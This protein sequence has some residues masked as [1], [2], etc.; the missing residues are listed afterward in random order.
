MNTVDSME[1]FLADITQ[2]TSHPPTHPPSPQSNHLLLL[3]PTH[4]LAHPPTHPPT[5]KGR[6][7]TVLP[8]VAGLQLPQEKLLA[9]YEQV[10]LEL[11]EMRET[12]LA[13]EMLRTTEPL[14]ALKMQEPERYFRLETFLNRQIHDAHELYAYGLNKDRRRQELADMLA[15]EVSVVPPSRLL[16]L[17]QQALKYQQLQ[18]LLPKDKRYDLFRGGA[19]VK[20]KDEAERPPK[21]LAGQVKFGSKT[22]PECARFSPDGQHLVTGSL[23]GFVEVWDTDSCRLRKELPYQAKE[24]FMMHDI[25]VLCLTFSRDGEMLVSG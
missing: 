25:A 3:Y 7:D 6:W 4:P 14:A 13:R 23:D 5:K 24:E 21:K 16:A 9:V 15:Q 22:H 18:G 1:N 2:G 11:I 10:C 12:E 17:L 19:R 8:Q 20:G